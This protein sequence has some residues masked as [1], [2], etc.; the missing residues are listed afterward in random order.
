L[1]DCVDTVS[2]SK[3]GTMNIPP[4][5]AHSYQRYESYPCEPVYR[6]SSS[7]ALKA[8]K[9]RLDAAAPKLCM[10]NDAATNVPVLDSPSQG[11]QGQC[12][13]DDS[14][15]RHLT[16]ADFSEETITGDGALKAHLGDQSAID[17]LHLTWVGPVATRRDPK[18]R[19][20]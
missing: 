6:T 14:L 1:Y 16:I 15:Q 3:N 12:K 20:M 19:F 11:G 10:S 8:Y 9:D 4:S 7:F 13:R 17:P 5:F 2:K 18:C